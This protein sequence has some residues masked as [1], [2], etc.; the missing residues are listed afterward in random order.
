M[1]EDRSTLQYK[2]SV[3]NNWIKYFWN[4]DLKGWMLSRREYGS[5]EFTFSIPINELFLK[6]GDFV[7]VDC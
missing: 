7:V 1:A 6:G 2:L 4:V 5:L 3:L